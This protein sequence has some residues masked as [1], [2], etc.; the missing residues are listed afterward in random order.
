MFSE[1]L[2]HFM[3][4]H[5]LNIA[6]SVLL[7]AMTLG[8]VV[9]GAFRVLSW[10]TVSRHD[11]FASEFEKRVSKY[12]DSEVPGQAKRQSFYVLTKILLER[13]Y[14]E[15][16]ELRDRLMRRRKDRVSSLVDR[17]FLV[18]PGCAW[19]VKD[20]L[21]Q[22]KF[23]KWNEI[24][25][26]L[27]TVTKT[28]FSQNP[29]FN[30]IFGI[31]PISGFHDLSNI[32]PS[33]FVIGGIFGTFLGIV[34]GLPSLGKM[35]LQDMALTKQVM[36]QFLFEISFAMN[37]SIIGIMFSVC[38][39]ITNS[40]FNPERVYERVVDR[41]EASL[42]LLWHRCDSN[43]YPH[44]LAQFDEHRDP[45]E[46]LAEA[47]VNEGLAHEGRTRSLDEVRNKNKTG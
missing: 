35:N 3:S 30:K 45:A 39:T 25:P 34:K 10:Y 27:H 11:W 44:S 22:L 38:M 12:L 32:L 29:H 18:K 8:F 26:S 41:I 20:M 28:T 1:N 13:T 6:I 46:A 36:D 42:E 4:Q 14:Y 21:K 2:I 7:P 5:V 37:S 9:G 47:T 17:V 40:M 23:L 15:V 31:F 33:L 43:D 16:F 19:V 24:A